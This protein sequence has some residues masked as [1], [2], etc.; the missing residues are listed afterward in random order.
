MTGDE[1]EAQ[2]VVTDTVIGCAALIG[3]RQRLTQLELAPK[4]I[5]PALAARAGGTDR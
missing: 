4:L 3:C 1:D 2:D 5:M